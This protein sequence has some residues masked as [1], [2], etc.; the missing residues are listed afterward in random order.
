MRNFEILFDRA[1]LSPIAD[2]AYEPYGNLGFPAAHSD[3]P[4]IYANFV[5]SIDGIAS[6]LGKHPT[7]GDISHSEEDKWLMDL[8]RAHADA[9]IMGLNTLIEETRAAPDLNKGRGPVY[10]VQ[11]AALR[12]FRGR[13]GRGREKVIFVTASA[14]LEQEQYRVFDGDLV[15]AYVLTTKAGE[16]RLRESGVRTIIAG[17][18]G[19]VDLEL[20]LR[21]LRQELRIKHLLCE[22]GPT[23]YGHMSRAG[24]IDEKFVTISPIE[25]GLL[26]PPE[27]QEQESQ[28]IQRGA[29]AHRPTTFTAPGFL[30]EN[31]PWWEW[32]SCRRV[33]DHEFNRYR[34]RQ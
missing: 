1:E 10:R 21:R 24:L 13:L 33:G 20:G 8:L 16:S 4:W 12:E 30:P 32:M 28:D 34:R 9:I 2:P 7:G 17:E 31:A 29:P 22:G 23:L 15:D 14:R 25:I 26:V 18:A 5:Q 11:D 19:F 27:Q 3:R 6:F